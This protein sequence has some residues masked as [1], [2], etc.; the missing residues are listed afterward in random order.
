MIDTEWMKFESTGSVTAYLNY[1]GH[2]EGVATSSMIEQEGK[3]RSEAGYGT[4]HSADGH[5]VIRSPG[6]RI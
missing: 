5:G 6:G 4:D 1:K 3:G 2:M